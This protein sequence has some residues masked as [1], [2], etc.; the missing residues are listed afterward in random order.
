MKLIIFMCLAASAVCQTEGLTAEAVNETEYEVGVEI[1][2]EDGELVSQSDIFIHED[3][4]VEKP[5][6]ISVCLIKEIND[7]STCFNEKPLTFE[8][9][10]SIWAHCE[11]REIR[12]LEATEC[13]DDLETEQGEDGADESEPGLRKKRFYNSYGSCCRWQPF[14]YTRYFLYCCQSN[15]F[16]YCSR[17]CRYYASS[18]IWTRSCV[19]GYK[20]GYY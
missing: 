16:G 12:I 9:P 6:N 20:Y 19:Y 4:Q 18:I 13:E 2:D 8:L 7:T 3:F 11:G 1:R 17:R 14:Y 5:V 15:W 10:S